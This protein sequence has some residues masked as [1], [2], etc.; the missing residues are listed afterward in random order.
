MKRGMLSGLLQIAV[1]AYLGL[2]VLLFV[3]QRS[4]LYFPQPRD[5]AVPL[6]QLNA[7]GTRLNVSILDRPGADAVIYFGGNAEDVSAAIG[8]LA[9]AFPAH[10]VYALHYRGYGGSEGSPGED[11]LHADAAALWTHVAGRHARIAVVG[12]SLGSG[13]A[14][15]LAAHH[16]ATQL[17]LVTPYD[18]MV[19]VARA[20]YGWLPVGW[21]LRDRYESVRHAPAVRAPTLL[22]VAARDEVIPRESSERL[23][24]AFAPGVARMEVVA[25][26]DHNG[27]TLPALK[28]P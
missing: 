20:H 13:I 14:V 10:A 25:G 6:L 19:A 27:L 3:M 18:S 28:R 8:E 22:M 23:F 5:P 15:R 17:V 24:A 2:C 4:M 9:A 7:D 12:R 11:A 16:A 21:L 26:A 1:L